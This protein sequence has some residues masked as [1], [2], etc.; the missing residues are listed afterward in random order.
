[1]WTEKEKKEEARSKKKDLKGH[2]PWEKKKGPEVRK[3]MTRNG[4]QVAG[5]TGPFT[6]VGEKGGVCGTL[7]KG[8]K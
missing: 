5:K 4:I 7:K 6:S 1:V 3:K 8:G 2:A